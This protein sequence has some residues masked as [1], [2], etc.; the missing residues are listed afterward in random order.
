MKLLA[1][2]IRLQYDEN[3]KPEIVLTIPNGRYE[4]MQGVADLK[5]IVAK[6]K[7]LSVE[8]KQ[9]RAAR[10]LDANGYLWALLQQMAEVLKT[11]KDEIYLQMLERYGVFTHVIVKPDAAERIR[12]EW[13]TV[14]DLGEVKVNGKIGVQ[15]QC[16]YGSHTYDTK[17]FSVLLDGVIYE[18]KELGIETLPPEQINDMKNEW[19]K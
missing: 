12:N 7:K 4:A 10:S 2:K 18:A 14:R 6:D 3:S 19:G 9:H 1:D 15:L 17:E 8:I 11:S 5:E 13:R 16:Y